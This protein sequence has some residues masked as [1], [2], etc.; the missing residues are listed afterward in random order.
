MDSDAL[1][2]SFA[3]TTQAQQ[4]V[5]ELRRV[6]FRDDQ[7]VVAL[8]KRRSDRLGLLA[9]TLLRHGIPEH[10]CTTCDQMFSAGH[11]IVAVKSQARLAEAREILVRHGGMVNCL[12]A[13]G[14]AHTTG[15]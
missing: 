6:G 9:Q 2:A 10:I 4:A 12:E 3:E 15:K 11:A 14:A 1:V 5:S 7:L 8:Q 13:E